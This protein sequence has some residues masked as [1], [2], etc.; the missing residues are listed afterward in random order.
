[1]QINL[2]IQLFFIL[3]ITLII[4]IITKTYYKIVKNDSL[5]KNSLLMSFITMILLLLPVY[6]NN[7]NGQYLMHTREQTFFL[8][9]MGII[10]FSII[11]LMFTYFLDQTGVIEEMTIRIIF[12]SPTICECKN[13]ILENVESGWSYNAKEISKKLKISEY[14]TFRAL[15]L[16]AL[17]KKVRLA[18]NSAGEPIYFVL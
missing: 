15:N 9:V 8:Y 7:D 6:I 2:V 17:D 18:I 11:Y 4:V 16:L 5:I 14:K 12:K 10:T 1:M 13:L 3:S